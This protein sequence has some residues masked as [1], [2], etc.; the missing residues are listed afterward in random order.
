MCRADRRTE[1]P[2]KAAMEVIE[3]MAALGVFGLTIPEEFGGAG[4]SKI[5]M[6][7]VSEDR[8]TSYNVCYTKL[9][10]KSRRSCS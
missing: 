5:A 2:I 9:L 6:C 3:E 8:I 1:A 10:R 7:I 4:L